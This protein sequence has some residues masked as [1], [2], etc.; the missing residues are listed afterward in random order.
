LPSVGLLA[1]LGPRLCGQNFNDCNGNDRLDFEDLSSGNSKDC[2]QNGIPDE[3]DQLPQFTVTSRQTILE[4]RRPVA[5][6]AMDLDAD[7]DDD[8]VT[9]NLETAN[10]SILRNDSPTGLVPAGQEAVGDRPISLAVADFNMDAQPDLAIACEGAG[11]VEVAF[12]AADGRLSPSLE[13]PAGIRPTALFAEQLDDDGVPDLVAAVFESNALRIWR[14][15]P[16][17][18][19]QDGVDIP[20]GRL[21]STLEVSDFDG[22]GITDLATTVYPNPN[23]GDRINEL[24]IYRG[25]GSAGFI[26]YKTEMLTQ[27]MDWMVAGDFD[28]DGVVDIA[29]LV[30]NSL[31]LIWGRPGEGQEQQTIALDANYQRITAVDYDGDGDIDLI[32]SGDRLEVLRN[33]GLRNFGLGP[34][35]TKPRY[36]NALAPVDINDDGRLDLVVATEGSCCSFFG[37]S[38][39]TMLQDA[40]GNLAPS[41]EHKLLVEAWAIA[42]GEVDGDG[43][44]DL[45]VASRDGDITVLPNHDS[46]R[47]SRAIRWLAGGAIRFVSTHD[48]DGDGLVEI[49]IGVPAE[50]VVRIFRTVGGAH[51]DLR[52]E[53]SLPGFGPERVDGADLDGDS[54]IDLIV[55]QNF[56]SF[57]FLRNDG[58]F[59]FSEVKRITNFPGRADGATPFD[60][61]GDGKVDV[62]IG[63]QQGELTTYFNRGSFNFS[64]TRWGKA[65]PGLSSVSI[66]FDGDS[67]QDLLSV[68]SNRGTTLTRT[69]AGPRISNANVLM[70]DPR[71]RMYPTAGDVTGDGVPEILEIL[72]DAEPILRILS[73]TGPAVSM[74][75]DGNG[76][77]DECD[78]VL[79]D[80]NANGV[81]DEAEIASGQAADCN[82]NGVPDEC[83]ARPAIALAAGGTEFPVGMNPYTLV[84]ADL[85]GD[86]HPDVATANSS[87]ADVSVLLNDRG[88]SFAPQVRYSATLVSPSG[89]TVIGAAAIAAADIDLDGDTDLVIR[90]GRPEA[91]DSITV[92]FLQNRGDGSFRLSPQ[93][94]GLGSEE[95]MLL[96]TDITGDGRPDLIA[97]SSFNGFEV[98]Y[99]DNGPAGFVETQPIPLSNE[100]LPQFLAAK[101]LTG[102][103]LPELILGG[104]ALATLRNLG[105]SFADVSIIKQSDTAYGCA[106]GDLDSDLDV[107]LALLQTFA[108]KTRLFLNNGSGNLEDLGDSLLTPRA[109]NAVLI[110]LDGDADVELATAQPDPKLL[111]VWPNQ[112]ALQFGPVREFSLPPVPIGIVSA[113]VDGNGTQDLIVTIGENHDGTDRVTVALNYSGWSRDCDGN[114]NP[115]ECDIAS[116]VL[117]DSNEDGIADLCL[118]K[119][120]FGPGSPDGDVE[121]FHRGDS[122]A[123]GRLDI[124]DSLSTLGFLFLGTP[125]PP[126]FEAADYDNSQRVD[127]SDP[128]AS[129]YYLFVGGPG[130]APPGSVAEPCGED[131]DPVGSAGHLGCISYSPCGT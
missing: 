112:S 35:L 64:S 74:D 57:L 67:R 95:R 16:G 84:S 21:P 90:T 34:T 113:D 26:L 97:V 20:L 83:D 116:G 8:I 19:F 9:A 98:T 96:A 28:A 104:T 15:Q 91:S 42:A 39:L 81:L 52:L 121:W 11:T 125:N 60:M 45:V 41:T 14:S 86:S 27:T 73:L 49:L 37:A 88:L 50:D 131:S 129:L 82:S 124:S 33:E 109:L 30:G 70:Q 92:T 43:T 102:D 85:D 5:L 61:D 68:G 76:I 24:R 77:P 29:M 130:P 119:L 6:V 101:D 123:D 62:T 47:F 79:D 59:S 128:I 75:R 69:L 55:F 105:G 4:A 114:Q 53:L 12:G 66:D 48:L 126:C 94:F 71:A 89:G 93:G 117:S 120:T 115:D 118:S 72:N 25:D 2:N 87:S 13:L 38:V 100:I 10:L 80:C 17:G 107:D 1:V 54:D 78:L 103:G 51:Y 56:E 23:S 36:Q 65:L 63:P 99:L 40:D 111:S 122:N 3:C 44:L 31:S 18:G 32:L 106:L 108:G 58:D 110:D 46:G 7:G 22:D 127:I